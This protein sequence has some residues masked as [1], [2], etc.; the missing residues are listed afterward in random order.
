[1][2]AEEVKNEIFDGATPYTAYVRGV[3]IDGDRGV[4]VTGRDDS[5]VLIEG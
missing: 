5:A 2:L 4:L 1:M 3:I